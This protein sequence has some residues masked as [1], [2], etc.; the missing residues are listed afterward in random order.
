MIE[1]LLIWERELKVRGAFMRKGQ[2]KYAC[3]SAVL[4]KNVDEAGATWTLV[5]RDAADVPHS[6][7]SL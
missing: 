5:R 7:L 6:Y 2:L 4:G 1:G 3:V